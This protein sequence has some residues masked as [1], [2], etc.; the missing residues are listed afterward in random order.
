MRNVRTVLTPALLLLGTGA[1]GFAISIALGTQDQRGRASSGE[2]SVVKK[3]VASCA[4]I[5]EPLAVAE[6]DT[7]IH[8]AEPGISSSEGDAP[9]VDWKAILNDF[10]AA[11]RRH[12]METADI[13]LER[14]L[15]QGDAAVPSILELL[16]SEKDPHVRLA[17]IFLL[18]RLGDPRGI[19]FLERLA[20]TATASRDEFEAGARGG[21]EREDSAALL[22]L[23]QI[24]G[25]EAS[26]AMQRITW[27]SPQADIRGQAVSLL[28]DRPDAG[29]ALVQT[30]RSDPDPVVRREALLALG[31][32]TTEVHVPDLIG[33]LQ[34]DPDENVRS[35]AAYALGRIGGLQAQDA[36][37]RTVETDL[38]GPRAQASAALGISSQ[39][40]EH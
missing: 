26:L 16:A 8:P 18:G 2:I 37:Q 39:L 27:Q 11:T 12:D 6:S 33:I 31:R 40:E 13:L 21:M 17:L 23:G 35:G 24:P 38:P 9:D 28:A 32:D 36:L 1:L 20:L 7:A 25:G 19:P 10:C 5:A 34:T 30:A 4:R 15:A 29:D 22:A 14:I 3:D